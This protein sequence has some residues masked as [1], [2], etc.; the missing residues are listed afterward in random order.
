MSAGTQTDIQT[1]LKSYLPPWFGDGPTPVLDSL[2]GGLASALSGLYAFYAYA[3]RQTRL[4]TMD[5]FWLDLFAVDYFGPRIRR[6]GRGD[7]EFRA[8][9]IANLF[10]P[11][12]TRASMEATL[13][14]LTGYEPDI[15]EPNRP[16]DIGALNEPLSRGYCRVARM[17]S[18]AVPYTAM[19]IVYRPQTQG[20]L[21]GAMFC[22]A[23]NTGLHTPLSNDYLDSLSLTKRQVSDA[24]I[25]D[26][27]A[28]DKPAGTIPWT[29]LTSAVPPDHIDPYPGGSGEGGSGLDFESAGNSEYL[30]SL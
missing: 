18:L 29:A 1:R 10:R 3:K 16:L 11:H 9:I 30:P 14:A 23:P 26:A 13:L 7:D 17:G 12:A 8:W 6:A 22:R 21:G 4:K 25:Y 20:G 19:M 2:L 5:G 15:F 27:I 28:H 24:E